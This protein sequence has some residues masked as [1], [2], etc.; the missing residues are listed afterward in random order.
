M[1]VKIAELRQRRAEL[2]S[3]LETLVEKPAEFDKA[4]KD[5]L[6]LDEQIKRAQKSIELARGQARPVD[7]EVVEDIADL[8]DVALARTATDRHSR[9]GWKFDQYVRQARAEMAF[10]VDPEKH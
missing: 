6:A 7:S 5:V 3:T 10:R 8:A 9:A 1:P 4:E 2:A